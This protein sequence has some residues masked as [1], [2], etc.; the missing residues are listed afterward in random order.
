MIEFILCHIYIFFDNFLV[1]Y[2]ALTIL[3]FNIFTFDSRYTYMLHQRIHVDIETLS[4]SSSFILIIYNY[5]IIYHRHA[6]RGPFHQ[7]TPKKAARI[8]LALRRR[9]LV[10]ALRNST[11][12]G[13]HRHRPVVVAVRAHAAQKRRLCAVHATPS[14]LRHHTRHIRQSR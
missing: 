6:E 3:V 2:T 12:Q 5:C 13:E 10:R 9:L 7:A 1:V 14:A 4:N 8:E 11:T